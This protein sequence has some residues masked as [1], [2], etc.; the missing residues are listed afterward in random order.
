MIEGDHVRLRDPTGMAER[1]GIL[2]EHFDTSGS[3]SRLVY[4]IDVQTV[5]HHG[6]IVRS[7]WTYRP[8]TVQCFSYSPRRAVCSTQ[9]KR[10]AALLRTHHPHLGLTD[11]AVAIL[12]RTGLL[13]A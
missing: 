4:R 3:G 12:C 1:D 5:N 10:M 8:A 7:V 9:A 2:I 13:V 6:V 11:R